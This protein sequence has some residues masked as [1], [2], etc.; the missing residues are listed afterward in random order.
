ME[1]TP[2]VIQPVVAAALKNGTPLVALESAV[3]THGLPY[4]HNLQLALDMEQE[5]RQAGALPATIAILDRKVRVGLTGDEVA[6]LADPQQAARKISRRDF[7]IALASG[8][9]GGTTVAGTLIAAHLAGICVFAT[10][11]IGGVHRGAPFDVSADLH[12]LSLH[13]LVV[14]CAGAKSILDLPA[15][16]EILETQ[17]VPVIGYQTDEF[18]AF[19]SRSS[20]LPVNAS[21]STPAELAQIA[22]RQWQMGLPGAILAVVP[23]PEDSAIPAEQIEAIIQTAVAEAEEKGIRGAAV[24][25]YL[26]GRVNDLSK[27]ASMRANLALLKNNARVAAQISIELSRLQ[28]THRAI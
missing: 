24:T 23:P 1:T 13:P 6:R 12:E 9:N 3:I 22:W 15:T 4:P 25:P 7:G 27:G 5:V 18:P 11:G 2:L 26:L 20:G 21:V 19:F 16:L 28:P 14:V 10:G 17:G 8:E